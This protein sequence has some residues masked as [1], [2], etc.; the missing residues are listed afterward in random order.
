MESIDIELPNTLHYSII[1]QPRGILSSN[2]KDNKSM[3]TQ[4]FFYD[5]N[6]NRWERAHI[7][8]EKDFNKL[9]V[10][11]DKVVKLLEEIKNILL[12]K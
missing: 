11:D 2:L 12:K 4:S 9:L 10:Q 8:K 7:I 6:T 1:V 5:P 3:F